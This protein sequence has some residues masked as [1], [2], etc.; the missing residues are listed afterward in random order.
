[1]SRRGFTLIEL[2]TVIAIVA[3]LAS[4]LIPVVAVIRTRSK[5]AATR[6]MVSTI[7]L[8]LEQYRLEDMRRKLPPADGP[9]L[10]YETDDS[11]PPTTLNLIELAG[12]QVPVSY[13][14]PPNGTRRTHVDAW[15]RDL[16]YALDAATSG[17]AVKPAPLDDWNATGQQPFA[18]VY[19]LGPPRG[20]ETE[21][22]VPAQ[23]AGHWIY[24]TSGK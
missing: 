21:D 16:R 19:S 20:T 13:L 8:A 15:K 14:G 22:A 5:A 9:T 4:L 24:R 3:V 18:Y 7:S 11:R 12:Y 1:M 23:A 10:L 6:A 17:G 2:L